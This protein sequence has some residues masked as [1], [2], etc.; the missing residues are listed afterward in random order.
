MVDDA[1]AR[2]THAAAGFLR[3][4]FNK[5][6]WVIM[7]G[8]VGWIGWE[9]YS[10]RHERDAEKATNALF[11]ALSAETGSGACSWNPARAATP[12]ATSWNLRIGITCLPIGAAKPG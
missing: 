3:A 9:V 11:K 2:S 4:H 6:Q 7:I 10:W 12:S 8:L 5:V 1:L